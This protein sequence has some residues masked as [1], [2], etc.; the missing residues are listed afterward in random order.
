MKYKE[1]M[2]GVSFPSVVTWSTSAVAVVIWTVDEV[3]INSRGG[4]D[5][6]AVLLH[7]CMLVAG[8]LTL[9]AIAKGLLHVDHTAVPT[10][11]Y[12]VLLQVPDYFEYPDLNVV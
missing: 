10:C 5:G 4:V 2:F 7:H 8:C 3:I 1:Q 12:I 11:S 9:C 6:T